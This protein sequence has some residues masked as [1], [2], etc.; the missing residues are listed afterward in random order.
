MR[1]TIV[2]KTSFAVREVM[3]NVQLPHAAD[4]LD[5]IARDYSGPEFVW[6]VTQSGDMPLRAR[7]N[8]HGQIV[9]RADR[10]ILG[11]TDT[12]GSCGCCAGPVEDRC[13]CWN[14]Q[15]IRAGIVPKVCTR[16]S[17]RVVA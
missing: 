13:C 11:F 2:D 14:H 16:H 7:H 10:P 1:L 4:L 8:Q 15:D 12:L 3:E 17:P 6:F 9:D 5:W